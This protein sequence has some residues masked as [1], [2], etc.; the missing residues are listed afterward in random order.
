MISIRTNRIN[1]KSLHFFQTVCLCLPYEFH[2]ETVSAK[3][4]AHV[5][6]MYVNFLDR[7]GQ[8]CPPNC[9]YGYWKWK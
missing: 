4:A 8:C 3:R 9:R 7:K 6:L 5:C 2:S 1:T